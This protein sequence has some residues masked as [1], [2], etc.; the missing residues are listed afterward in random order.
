MGHPEIPL[1]TLSVMATP[2]DFGVIGGINAVLRDE[3]IDVAD[4]LDETGNVPPEVVFR[5][6]N[7]ARV[8]GDATAYAA[9]LANLE[10]SEYIAAHDALHTWAHD[11]I[12]FP[13]ACFKQTTRWLIRENRL[14]E[15]RLITARGQLDAGTISCPVMNAVGLADHLIP[16]ESN[17]PIFDLIPHLDHLEF[18]T[19]HVGLIVGGKAHRISVPA[20]ADWIDQ[21]CDRT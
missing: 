12:P 19:G 5:G 17:R 6:I 7:S 11:H 4:F 20:M 1:L 8:T 3:R 21:H 2:I 14:A 9:L 18:Q 15:N 10:S 16:I 13:G